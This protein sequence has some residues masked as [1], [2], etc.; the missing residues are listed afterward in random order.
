MI[1]TSTPNNSASGSL[2]PEVASLREVN[3][4]LT[5][6]VDQLQQQLD[7]FKRQLFGQKSEKR[8]LID[9]AIQASLFDGMLTKE[10][11]APPLTQTIATHERKVKTRDG[12]TTDSGLRFD[13]NVPVQV[14]EILPDELKGDTSD[15]F[16]IITHKVTFRLAQQRA[17]YVVIE[18]RRPVLKEKDTQR[19]ITTPAPTRVLDNSIADVSLLAGMLIDKFQFHLPLYRQHQRLSEAGITLSRSL[20]TQLTT[21]AIAL[22]RPIADA[23]CRSVLL[24]RVLAIDETPIKAG[25]KGPGKMKQGYFWPMY[26]DQGEVVFR[27]CSSRSGQHLESLLGDFQGTLLTDGYAAYERFVANKPG[28]THAQCWAH[29]RRGFEKALSMEPEAAGEALAIIGAMYQHEDAIREKKL[30]GKAMQNYRQTH[31]APIVETFW[32]WCD[33]QCYRQ[34]LTPTNPLSKALKYAMDRVGSLKVFLSDPDVAIDTNHLER[35]LRPIP[36]GK[37]N[38]LFCWTEAGAEDVATIQTL[39]ATCRIQG[40]NAYEY[41][42]D[43]LQRVAIHPA[44]E[45]ETLTPRLWKEHFSTQPLRSVVDKKASG[46]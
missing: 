30:S 44:S 4:S 46:C 27:Y 26:G 11:P 34:D 18:E 41:L 17:S 14:V 25:R 2:H 1:S 21:K 45:V 20:L 15:R 43:V 16:E 7:W 5:L 35:G 32:Q 3:A 39:L 24:S 40:V 9:P 12:C 22:L 23:Q 28:V 8:Q 42:V 37:K 33:Q 19:L 38:W 10:E 29:N 36:M 31:I 13:D 6:K